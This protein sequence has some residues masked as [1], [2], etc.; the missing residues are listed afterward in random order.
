MIGNLHFKMILELDTIKTNIKLHLL[1][2]N[3]YLIN[4]NICFHFSALKLI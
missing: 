4:K 1:G 3:S 2:S